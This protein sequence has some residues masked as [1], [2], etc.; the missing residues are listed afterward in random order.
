MPPPEL[1]T[2]RPRHEPE[3]DRYGEL[4]SRARS[5]AALQSLP[6]EALYR[7][8]GLLEL[9]LSARALEEPEL[10]ALDELERTLAGGNG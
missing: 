7:I 3:L 6:T 10:A 5:A 9:I 2:A 1:L 4:I 8:H